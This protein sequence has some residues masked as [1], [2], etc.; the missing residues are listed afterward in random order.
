[1]IKNRTSLS[2]KIACFPGGLERW[3]RDAGPRR[4]R[5]EGAGPV[6]APVQRAYGRFS[7]CGHIPYVFFF[8]VPFCSLRGFFFP[9]RTLIPQK[10]KKKKAKSRLPLGGTEGSA[11]SVMTLTPLPEGN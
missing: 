9:K 1:M 7:C 11:G 5:S 6:L 3:W 4:P 10:K 2:C 8:S